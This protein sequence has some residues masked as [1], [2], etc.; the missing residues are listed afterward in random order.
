MVAL[1]RLLLELFSATEL[2]MWVTHTEIVE[3]HELPGENVA[4]ATLAH[5]FVQLAVRRGRVAPALFDALHEL[6]PGRKDDID[7]VRS[8]YESCAAQF[9]PSPPGNSVLAPVWHK[10]FRLTRGLLVGFTAAW[11]LTR[12][13]PTL[14]VSKVLIT[15]ERSLF[16]FLP[17][18]YQRVGLLGVIAIL[19]LCTCASGALA[20]RATRRRS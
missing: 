5:D 12:A 11:L 8:L 7:R 19:F 2:R 13:Y 15:V 17:L 6:R 20:W 1:E 18:P 9:Q 14:D 4:F 3:V 10:R 16:K